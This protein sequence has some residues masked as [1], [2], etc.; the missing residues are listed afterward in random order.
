MGADSAV[1]YALGEHSPV[2]CTLKS[3]PA[4]PTRREREV[5]DLVTE[6]LTNKEIASRLTISVRTAQGHVEHLLVKLG[7][8]SRAQIAAWVVEESQRNLP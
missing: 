3:G 6:G 2:S 8:T 4:A 1:A 7:F 5:A